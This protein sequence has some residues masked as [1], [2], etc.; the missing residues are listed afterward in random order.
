MYL[1]T[2]PEMGPEIWMLELPYV[3]C[4]ESDFTAEI[5]T[6]VPMTRCFLAQPG[7]VL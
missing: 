3:E 1:S 2:A 5:I 7:M 4:C 6:S